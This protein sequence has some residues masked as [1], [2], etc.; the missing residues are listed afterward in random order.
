MSEPDSVFGAG[1]RRAVGLVA[2]REITTRIRGKAYRISTAILLVGVVAG[3]LISKIN[4]GS[5]SPSEV[6]FLPQASASAS[7]FR[8]AAEAVGQKVNTPTI[9]SRAEGESQLRKGTIDALVIGNLSGV[10]VEAKKDLDDNLRN[11]F[12][13]LVRQ[14]A[15]NDQLSKAGANPGEVNTA[16]ANARVD[17]HSLIRVDPNQGQRL[18]I[19]L[20]AGILVYLALMLYGQAVAQGVV[21]EKTSRIVEL[22]LTAIRPW[23]LL[24]GKVIGIG[25]LGLAQLVAVG[26]VGL[27]TG[28]ATH[29]LTIPGTVALEAGLAAFGWFLLGYLMF[30][31]MFAGL[32]ALVSRQEDVA[33]AVA[34]LTTLIILP[35]VL[36]IS[37]LPSNPGSGL[38]EVLSIIPLFSPTLMPMRLA[39]GVPAWE[40]VLAVALTLL[41]IGGLV[42]VAG[43]IY[44]NAVTRTGARVR[45]RDALS[46]I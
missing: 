12:T 20:I 13:V 28:L 3:I 44:G 39:A 46:P 43:R 23:Q 4:S 36:G 40:M 19:G 7:A 41:L 35:Y 29:V 34:P 16:V 10:Q 32:G 33:G 9:G 8:V 1:S 37:I 25:A 42:W 2:A 14:S 5:S 31:L 6:G 45:L 30:A 21:E 38:I 22:L 15:L 24:L 11:A 27:G 18:A 17:V 26:V